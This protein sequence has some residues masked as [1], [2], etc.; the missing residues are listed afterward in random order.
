MSGTAPRVATST[1]RPEASTLSGTVD[2]LTTHSEFG[3]YCRSTVVMVHSEREAGPAPSLDFI[4]DAQ[5]QTI[6]PCE[7]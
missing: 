4:I 1:S 7:M 2:S 5:E 3:V 6:I